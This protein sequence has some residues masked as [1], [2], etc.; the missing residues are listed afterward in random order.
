MRFAAT[1]RALRSFGCYQ[2]RVLLLNCGGDLA[3][4]K[5]LGF[6]AASK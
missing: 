1:C 3:A 4:A 5:A 6:S 2:L